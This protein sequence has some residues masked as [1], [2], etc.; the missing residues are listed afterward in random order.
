MTALFIIAG[1]CLLLAAVFYWFNANTPL[2]TP[3][4]I[5]LGPI[6]AV[7]FLVA[8]G[9]LLAGCARNGP[10]TLKQLPNGSYCDV[11]YDPERCGP[12]QWQVKEQGR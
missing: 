8:V 4:P 3:L 5:L 10:P 9:M 6:G 2:Q 1:I 7:C 11:P 12:R